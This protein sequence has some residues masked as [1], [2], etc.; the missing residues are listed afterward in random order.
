MQRLRADIDAFARR[1]GLRSGVEA[2]AILKVVRQTLLEVLPEVLHSEVQAEAYREGI[3]Y[4]S[5]PTGSANATLESYRRP[6][7]EALK[8][9]MGRSKVERI[10]ARARASSELAPQE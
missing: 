6:L 5:V 1:Y 4:L 3:L 9:K 10:I 7:L 8:V 2:A